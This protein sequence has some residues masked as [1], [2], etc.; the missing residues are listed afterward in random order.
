[1][2]MKKI[3]SLIVSAMAGAFLSA[4]LSAEIRMSALFTD[5]MVLQ[6]KVLAPVWGTAAPGKVVTVKPSWS[7]HE[8]KATAGNDGR[9]MLEIDTP[10]A[11]GPHSVTVMENGGN[12]VIINNV[13]VGEVWLC[14]GQSN[15]EMPVKGWGK[16]LNYEQ[17]LQE[18]ASYPEIRLLEVRRNVS[19]QPVDDF[20]ADSDG[21]MVCSPETLA[22]FSATAYFFGREL[23]RE[24]KVP[25]GL[26]NTSWGGTIIE[27]WISRGALAGVKDLEKE[28]D[29]VA[30][31]PLKAED[32]TAVK[33]SDPN[34]STVLYNTMIAPLVPY[35]IK[36][37]IWYQG[38][39]NVDRAYQY[40]DLMTIMIEDWR[41]A[42]GYDFPFYITQLAN[43]LQRQ[44]LPGN[45]SWAELREAQDIAANVTANTEM[46]VTIDIGEADDIHPKNK[47]EVGRRLA[48]Q[49]MN[50][51]Y[52]RKVICDGP[53]FDGYEISGNSITLKFRSAGKGLVAKDGKLE[54]FAI[55]GADR[56]F[57]W[58]DARIA[59]N[60]VVVTCKDVER[61]LAVRYA[62][63]DNPLGNL[64]NSAGLPAG[65]FR[66]DDWPGWTI[67]KTSRR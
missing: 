54:G 58:A 12:T 23:N 55:A 64:Y 21:W 49:A 26:I 37:A 3:I 60:T 4:D 43:Y 65:P 48:L 25:V 34:W 61:P 10:K 40:R 35:A 1:M 53:V 57:H 15:M 14:S 11:G 42:W 63:G 19:P 13:M 38:C 9:W 8:Y 56:H 16:V 29:E 39:S 24:L 32:G 59:G 2:T 5:N 30:A 45:S 20:K 17:E 41:K 66:T 67:G 7:K 46:A 27:A 44:M 62:W 31:W 47:Q 33:Y 28:A 22:E 52:G 50:S 36:G 51:T 6:Q 18:A